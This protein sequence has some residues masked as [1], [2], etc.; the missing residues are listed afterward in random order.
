MKNAVKHRSLAG[1]K[2]CLVSA[3]AALLLPSCASRPVPTGWTEADKAYFMRNTNPDIVDYAIEKLKEN[4]IVMIGDHGHASAVPMRGVISVLKAWAEAM[5][6]GKNPDALPHALYFVVERDNIRDEEVRNRFFE[7]G[8]LM[9]ILLDVDFIG[10][11]TN[12]AF[13]YFSDLR[14]IALRIKAL[15]SGKTGPNRI[16]FD[17]VCPEM[18][19]DTAGWTIEKRNAWFLEERDLYASARVIELLEKKPEARAIVFYGSA[20]MAKDLAPKLDADHTGYYM[21]HYLNERFANDGGVFCIDQLELSGFSRI[22]AY[23]SENPGFGL[24]YP[25]AQRL[26]GSSD[27]P[28]DGYLFH[29]PAS[30]FI[31]SEKIINRIFSE[32]IVDHILERLRGRSTLDEKEVPYFEQLI[33]KEWFLY[34]WL[35]GGKDMRNTDVNDPAAVRKA[36]EELSAWKAAASLDVVEDI[37]SLAVFERLVD[38]FFTTRTQ[39]E[40]NTSIQWHLGYLDHKDLRSV[41]AKL[42]TKMP[43]QL[44]NMKK[45]LQENKTEIVARSLIDIMWI[46]TEREKTKAAAV[47][48]NLTGTE[49]GSPKEWSEWYRESYE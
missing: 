24:D 12:A 11:F 47:L 22:P 44:D 38:W 35:V 46:G 20:H 13:E 33:L 27:Q 19:I 45:H 14:D 43:E 10:T 5:E 34:I 36:A 4:R 1:M 25:V 40:I 42:G 37:A 6:E 16:F 17:V 28:P 30:S 21:G 39:E 3:A 29:G 2:I 18:I 32:S 31:H 23:V 41:F 9:E 48:R 7:S 26:F 49:L 15:N 8:N